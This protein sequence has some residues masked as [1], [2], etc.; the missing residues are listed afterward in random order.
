MMATLK[1][2][3]AAD[4]RIK[5]I[6]MRSSAKKSAVPPKAKKETQKTMTTNTQEA[7]QEVSNTSL[8][9]INEVSL[10]IAI[11][12]QVMKELEVSQERIDEMTQAKK[13]VMGEISQLNDYLTEIKRQLN[14]K[15][16]QMG[17]LNRFFA[18]FSPEAINAIV[19]D[20]VEAVYAIME[21]RAPQKAAK[22][23][24]AAATKTNTDG[25]AV[26]YA[27]DGQIRSFKTKTHLTY[28]L[29]QKTGQKIT[30]DDL[31]ATFNTQTGIVPFSS[32]HKD[33]GT[34]TASFDG[35]Q[36]SITLVKA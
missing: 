18:K 25:Y 26:S 6:D 17:E 2:I 12:A 36:V 24:R 21:G 34:I 29:G 31:N 8:T 5:I 15:N 7:V 23:T 14:E 22:K 10:R 4:P 1:D 20:R 3:A 9:E 16:T 35:I 13:A 32:E 11:K 30:V 33:H 28:W 27:I 19:T